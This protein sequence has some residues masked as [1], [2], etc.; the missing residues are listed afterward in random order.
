MSPVVQ[1]L[2][3]PLLQGQVI[4][5]IDRHPDMVPFACRTNVQS[6]LPLR[7]PK[8]FLLNAEPP[9]SGMCGQFLLK[10]F[11][12]I[13][14]GRNIQSSVL[15]DASQRLDDAH[16]LCAATV[17]V[18]HLIRHRHG[19]LLGR[20]GLEQALEQ[21]IAHKNTNEHSAV[22][23]ILLLRGIMHVVEGEAFLN[24]LLELDGRLLRMFLVENTKAVVMKSRSIDNTY[25]KKRP[26]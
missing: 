12:D 8:G 17:R 3:R 2:G 10:G 20:V 9:G 4:R 15:G 21:Q 11:F 13:K 16:H 5:L 23:H 1:Y 7:Y 18:D 22:P 24:H 26:V 25:E 19:Y 14:R 6:T